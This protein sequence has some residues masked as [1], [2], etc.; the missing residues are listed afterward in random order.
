MKMVYKCCIYLFMS[1]KGRS[2]F[3]N[4]K[5]EQFSA[6]KQHV[7]NISL[8]DNPWL[9]NFVGDLLSLY[10]CLHAKYIHRSSTFRNRC[11]LHW[12]NLHQ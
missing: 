2:F 9:S 10:G 12:I 3:L 4:I 6:E 8:A 11:L 5:N 1:W 7:K